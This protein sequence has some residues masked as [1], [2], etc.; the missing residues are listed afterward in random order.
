MFK[1]TS[2]DTT[3]GH[4]RQERTMRDRTTDERKRDGKGLSA[5]PTVN[6]YNGISESL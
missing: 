3:H 6:E 2:V 4:A 5:P 1:Q